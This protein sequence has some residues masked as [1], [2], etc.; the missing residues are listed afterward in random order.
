LTAIGAVSEAA[1]FRNI[2]A[3][4]RSGIGGADTLTLQEAAEENDWGRVSGFMYR[5]NS[6]SNPGTSDL[7]G[8]TLHNFNEGRLYVA[9]LLN[10][11]AKDVR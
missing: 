6:S 3:R 5:A 9:I 7:G 2:E 8:I 1:R 10:P 11:A 4:V